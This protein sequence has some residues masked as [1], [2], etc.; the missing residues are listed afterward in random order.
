MSIAPGAEMRSREG[1]Y[2]RKCY[3]IA[4]AFAARQPWM[5]A[6]FAVVWC[7]EVK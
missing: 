5:C 4:L 3:G 7:G 2:D 1:R 6:A